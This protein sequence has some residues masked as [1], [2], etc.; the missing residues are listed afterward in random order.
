MALFR[1]NINGKEVTGRPG[2]TILEVARE[3]GIE[4]PTLCYDER[5]D[6]YGACGLCVV[7]VEGIP[8]LLRSCATEISNGMIIHTETE[9]VKGSRKVALELL[10]SDHVGDC[11]PPCRQACPAHTDCQGYVG[12]IANGQYREALELIK[13]QLPLPASIG[14]VCPHPCEDACRRQL[15][16]EPVSIAWLKQFVADVDLKSGDAFL[17]ETKPPSGKAVAIVGGGPA[18][19]TAAYFLA[20]EGHQVVI[21]E[22]M[23]KAGG[24]LRYGIPQYRL[25]KEVLDQE[26]E[27]I[28]R[29][30][31]DIVTNTRVGKDVSFDYLRQSF[32][33]VYVA[34]GAWASSGMRCPGEKLDGVI[35]GIEFLEAV[36]SHKPVRL[37]KKVAVVGGGN[38][39]MD[40][41]RTAV[42]LGAEEVYLLYRRTRAEMPAADIEVIE[43]EEE[44]V[45]FH[46]LVAP[47][48]IIGEDGKVRKIKL[49]QMELGEPD[50]SGRR[51]PVPIPGRETVL[52]V[53]NVIAAIG[54]KVVPDGID[55]VALTKWNTIIADEQTFM[56]NLPGVF[57][58]GDA[59]N[60]G[61]GIAIEAI[62]HARKAA[63]TIS[64]YL[65]GEVVPY[66]EPYYAK[67]EDLTP[68]DFADREKISR[69]HMAHLAPEDRKHNF[70][71][72]VFGYTEE[73][74]QKDAMRCLEC[75][76]GDVFE[77]KLIRYA[78]EYNVNPGRVAGEVHQRNF[79]D[80]HPF[81]DRNP[82]KCI[83]C[84]LCVRVC[85]EIMGVTALGLVNRGFDTVVQPE[86]GLPLQETGCL[87]CGQCVSVCPTGALQERLTI[88]KSVPLE[89]QE[90]KT[91]CSYCSVGCNL[92]LKTKGDLLVKS[93]PD[94]G[95]KVDGG[96]L[97]VKGRFGFNA[98]Q[99]GQRLT[100]PLVRQNG[101][102]QETSWDEAYLYI[103]K[104]AQSVSSRFG[105]AALAVSVSDRY[106]NEE[107]YLAVKLARD[108]LKTDQVFSFNGFD[109][110]I[111]DVLGYD[112]S[113]GTFDEL[114]SADTILL[115][116]SDVMKDHPIVGL[117]IKEAVKNG[118]KLI[119]INP[120]A[121]L[122][123]EWAWK[124]VY[125][126]NNVKFFK[127][128]L[129]AVIEVGMAPAQ[130]KADGF[131]E[132][133]ASLDAVEIRD[134]AK[135][136]G[137]IYGKAK[138]AMIVFSQTGVS[139]AGAK[140]LADLA[141]VSGHM[142]R[143]RNGI[144][145]LKPKANS[146]G[147]VDMGAG[148]GAAGIISRIQADEIKG[149]LI[150]GED[151]PD[152]D[153]CGLELLVVQDTHL[154]ET[155]KKADVV[156]PAVSFTESEGTFTSSERR[157]QKLNQ[158]IPAL[159]GISNWEVIMNIS[160]S[161]GANLEYCCPECVLGEIAVNIS[162]Y[163][164][165]NDMPEES[166]V[167]WPVQGSPVLYGEK[168][169]FADGKAKLQVVDDGPLF[170]QRVSTDY[171]EKTFVEFLKEKQIG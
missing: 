6:I 60:N 11:R 155:A 14:R 80:V 140:L 108:V 159:S 56:T 74:A 111:K 163:R 149:M 150:F 37:G 53:D 112:A 19:L 61:P 132:L 36:A 103:A 70:R 35:G 124:K 114:L 134:A 16:E 101:E 144:I 28:E 32:D 99:K 1:L 135:E 113:S 123:D 122:A 105:S 77:C 95:S 100:K 83:L 168:F 25:P 66:Q 82:D 91:I 23:P 51:R 131:A 73:Q 145:Q 170:D 81:I 137:E 127:E 109:G 146:Q 87:S 136:I 151:V 50:A 165:L 72:I 52:D 121:S 5:I 141:V 29:M 26:I 154:T 18:G 125:P 118:A 98:A 42:R 119:N 12:L 40:A 22:A 34:I 10:L 41:C 47:L 88:G 65:K 54:Q 20:K 110:G 27:I 143:A 8:K 45:I 2:Q 104:K 78:H 4:I 152:I 138:K 76:C 156:L 94:K 67:R 167:F 49:Q 133:K 164:G 130:D 102:L 128:I 161:L 157:I 7:E 153:F 96:L 31:V 69:P 120:G 17:P 90:T 55:G 85:D 171:V 58:G 71:E 13:E 59:I 93:V 126:E 117:K 46:F 92:N 148:R 48:E 86:F 160:N 24:M 116:G 43:A 162:A 158:A 106:T 147:L 30:G 57:A 97:C 84:G 129:K 79:K 3:N 21:Y 38:T 142:G 115:V 39:A 44:G 9:R 63:D 107:I 62:G 68:E 89:T 75:G 64:S 139:E 166:S 15:V 169:N 33:A